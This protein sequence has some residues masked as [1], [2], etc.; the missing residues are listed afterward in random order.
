MALPLSNAADYI[1]GDRG[2]NPFARQLLEEKGQFLKNKYFPQQTEADIAHKNALANMAKEQLKYYAPSIE[3]E[4]SARKSN[5]EKQSL[6]NEFPLLRMPGAAGQ[7]GAAL[8]LNKN[9]PNALNMGDQETNQQPG[10]SQGLTNAIKSMGGKV[11]GSPSD[12]ILNAL[13]Q[14]LSQKQA[15]ADYNKVRTQGYEYQSLPIQHKSALLAQAAGM[16]VSPEK[17][18]HALITGKSID[19]IAKE[20]GFTPGNL[21]EPIYPL[22]TAGQT[23]LKQ[24]QQSLAEIDALNSKLTSA[25]GPYIQTIDGYSPKQTYEA[26]MGLNPDKQSKFLAAKALV[27]EMSA[28]RGKAMGATVGVEALREITNASMNNIKAMQSLV[29]PEVYEKANKY[30]DN[31]LQ[32]TVSKANKVATT[33]V[34]NKEENSSAPKKLKWNV[35]KQDWEE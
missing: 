25:L 28:L 18:T 5:I 9:N 3:S 35:E 34:N 26:L 30:V 15:S 29:T 11:S 13:N 24:R 1:S 23:Q 12:L 2:M 22:T 27:P 32:D 17:A 31:W 33:F 4:I 20:Q 8:Y 19:D 7:I 21:P 16:G 10:N 14:S 6:E